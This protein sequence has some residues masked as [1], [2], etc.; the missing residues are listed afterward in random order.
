[1]M[2]ALI[3]TPRA[4]RQYERALSWWYQNRDKAP[5]LFGNE[6][7]EIT[8]L[9]VDAP[10]VGQ[11]VRTRRGGVRR[12]LMEHSR[13]YVYYSVTTKGDIAVLSVWHAS[14]RPPRL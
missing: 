8:K 12:V 13:Y 14:R 3:L 9:I 2:R 4:R 5:R 10:G 7:D 1:M 11:Y 6:F